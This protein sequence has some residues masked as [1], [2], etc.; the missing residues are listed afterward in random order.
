MK[1]GAILAGCL[2]LSLTA[3]CVSTSGAARTDVGCSAFEPFTL[4]HAQWTELARSPELWRT[5]KEQVAYHNRL[6]TDLCGW[7]P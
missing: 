4:T 7:R 1:F 2:M 6:G 3:S 5:L